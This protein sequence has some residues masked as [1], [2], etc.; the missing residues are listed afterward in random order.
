MAPENKRAAKRFTRAT[1]VAGLLLLGFML[2]ATSAVAADDSGRQVDANLRAADD[3]QTVQFVLTLGLRNQD[4]LQRE[5][6]D[7]YDRSSPH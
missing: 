2:L 4:Q 6:K 3:A 5:L 1:L 7:M